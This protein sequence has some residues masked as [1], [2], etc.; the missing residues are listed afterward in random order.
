[1]LLSINNIDNIPFK[2]YVLTINLKVI[3]IYV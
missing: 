2:N 3:Y 1:M